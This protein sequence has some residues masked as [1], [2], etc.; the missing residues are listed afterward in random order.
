MQS[1][2]NTAL[3][4]HIKFLLWGQLNGYSMTRPFLSLRRVWLARLDQCMFKNCPT[5]F[6]AY[7]THL[8]IICPTPTSK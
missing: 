1:T 6:A 2:K 3:I 4:G 8:T 7:L 5:H